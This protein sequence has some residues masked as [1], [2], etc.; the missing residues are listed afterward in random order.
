VS[1]NDDEV[2]R[3]GSFTK[4]F[5]WG[6]SRQ[7]LRHLHETIRIG[8]GDLMEDVPRRTFRERVAHSGRPDYIPINFFLFNKIVDDV[9]YIVADELVFQALNFPHSTDFDKLGLFAFNLSIVGRWKGASAYQA[10]PAMWAHHYVADRVA[11][12]L[13]WNSRAVSADDIERFV[14]SDRRYTGQTTRKLATNLNYL[15]Q[16]GRLSEFNR[17][18]VER[19]WTSALFLTLDR[20]I[21]DRQ[22][23]GLEASAS[24]YQ[25]I[26]DR[27]RFHFI[28]GRRSVEK[29]LAAKHLLRLYDACGARSRFSEDEV[30]ARQ[31][32]L[33]PDLHWYANRPE[34]VGAVH[35][36]NY[37]I[38]KVIPRACTMLALYIAGF[39]SF[40]LD[41][42]E[43]MNVEEF[44]R[45]RTKEA[46]EKLAAAGLSPTMTAE[47]LLK[48]TRGR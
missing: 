18:S 16:I 35:P 11:Q 27:S 29:D 41:E 12:E 17:Q 39:V 4:N 14:K 8:F 1:T 6:D 45:T 9:D 30:R 43:T 42:L 3:P 15:Y 25:I 46:L 28:S 26:L 10:R 19:W 36:T 22:Q 31:K 47:E 23:R 21:E 44:V 7:G 20:L 38:V 37:R 34:P 40:D 2:W 13:N 24:Q 48:L 5:S 32:V 33:L